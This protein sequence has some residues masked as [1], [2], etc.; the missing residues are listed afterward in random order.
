VR[1][2]LQERINPLVVSWGWGEAEFPERHDWQGTRDPAAWLAIPA[3]I[4]FQR[5]WGWDEVRTRSH[6]LVERFVAGSGLAPAADGFGQM[7]AVELPPDTQVEELQ[8]RLFDEHR[9]EVPCFEHG[10]RRLLRISV[11]GYNEEADMEALIG[12]LAA[13]L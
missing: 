6:A 1:P 12:A 11:Q 10:G 13:A 2:E 5:E 7:L 4:E 9:I 8:R 3:A